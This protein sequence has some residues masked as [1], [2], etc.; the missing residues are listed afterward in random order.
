MK[1]PFDFLPLE[2]G[3]NLILTPCPGTKGVNLY[4]SLQQLVAA[5]ATAILTLM[6]KDEMQ[7][8]EVNNLPKLSA[9]LGLQWFHLPIEDDHAPGPL[10][11]DPWRLDKTDIDA[12]LDAGKTIAIHC[13]GG[14]GRTGLVAVRILLERGVKLDDA[15]T[16]VRAIRS[17]ALR[18]PIQLDY[19][20]SVALQVS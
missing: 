11:E 2:N 9:Q 7:R 4:E 17:N 8:N 12:L 10:F 15:I 5:G 1:H 6:P 20:A 13:K 19:I 16:R 3:A 18:I 14:T